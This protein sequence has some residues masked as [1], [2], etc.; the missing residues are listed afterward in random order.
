MFKPFLSLFFIFICT[1][2]FSQILVNPFAKPDDLLD[3]DAMKIEF[4]QVL[5]HSSWFDSKMTCEVN[6]GQRRSPFRMKSKIRNKDKTIVKFNSETDII[7]AFYKLGW[8]FVQYDSFY[9]IFRRGV[10]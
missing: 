10:K 7:N 2:S 3:V 9:F 5:P 8:T 1:C 4:I 6:Y